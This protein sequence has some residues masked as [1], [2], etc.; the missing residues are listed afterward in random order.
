MKST[1]SGE[2]ARIPC[3]F[4]SFGPMPICT[5][6]VD[7]AG[8]RSCMARVPVCSCIV[9]ILSQ[10]GLRSP[11]EFTFSEILLGFLLKMKSS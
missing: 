2:S 4:V 7:V 6:N 3:G 5:S 10:P 8:G 1:G 11:K 9:S